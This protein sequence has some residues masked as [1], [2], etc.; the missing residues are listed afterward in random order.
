MNNYF[1]TNNGCV[2]CQGQQPCPPQQQPCPSP[3]QPEPPQKPVCPCSDD[4][5][6]LLNL[7]CSETLR[8]L[9]DFATFAFVT[10]F[11]VLG[12]ALEALTAGATPADNLATP[13][14]TYVCG[15]DN[16]G[17]ISVSGLLYPPETGGTALTPTVTQ[18]AL[19][20]M[21]ALAFAA[22]A[23]DDAAANFQTIS[24]T[25]GQ[26]LRPARPKPC[27]SLVDA[28]TGAA[29]VRTSTVVAGPLV[30][31]N[32]AIIG[33][34]GDVLVMANSTDNRFYFICANQIDY[35]A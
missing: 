23:T 30:I 26:A 21:K 22:S 10:D 14:A 28:L 25:L 16:C 24:Q 15:S 7:I 1:C 33:Q 34:L 4:F 11:Y 29:A 17:T 5:R 3:C 27:N 35:M 12:S 8:P 6:Q 13:A 2:P 31:A 9:V 18:V 19:C 32:S 20:R